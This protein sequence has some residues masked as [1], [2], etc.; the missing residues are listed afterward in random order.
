MRRE[1]RREDHTICTAIAPELVFTVRTYA[2]TAP[3]EPRLVR[4]FWPAIEQNR[5][6]ATRSQNKTRTM[7]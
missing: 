3:Y 2:T 1:P 7:S 6:S 4:T 5:R